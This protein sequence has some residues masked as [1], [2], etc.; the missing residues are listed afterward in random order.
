MQKIWAQQNPSLSEKIKEL[1]RL[2]YG[3][4]QAVVEAEI[5]KRSRL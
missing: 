2:R 3:R 5:A 1:S 4:D